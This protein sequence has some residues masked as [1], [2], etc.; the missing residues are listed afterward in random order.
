MYN[1][2][3]KKLK[4]KQGDILSLNLISDSQIMIKGKKFY[5]DFYLEILKLCYAKIEVKMHLIM[6]KLE[7]VLLPAKLDVKLYSTFLKILEKKPDIIIRHCG[8]KEHHERYF[9]SFYK[10]L[11]YYLSNY[12]SDKIGPLLEKKDLWKYYVD[13][14][15]KNHQYFPNLK[16]PNELII[17]MI[18][19][20]PSDFSTI[21]GALSFLNDTEKL[22]STINDNCK[23]I[24]DCCTKENQLIEISEISNP[25]NT[26]DL[27]KVIDIIEKLIKYQLEKGKHFISFG[28]KFWDAYIKLND[29]KNLKNLI[30]INK[31][32]IQ[33][34]KIDKNLNDKKLNLIEKIHN[35]GLE[36]IKKGEIKNENLLN[37]IQNEDIYFIDKKYESDL[38]RPLSI[39]KGIDLDTADQKFYELW[40]FSKIFE[41]YSFNDS[42]KK[43]LIDKIY[44][45]K[46]FGKV[47]LLFNI[48]TIDNSVISLLRQ[49]FINIIKTYKIEKCPNF[50]KDMALFIY[51]VD[52]K[53]KKVKNFMEKTIEQNIS[54]IQT[55][56]DI[57][58]HLAAN[59]KDISKEV[60]GNIINYF[61]KNKMIYSQ[62]FLNLLK[63]GNNNIVTSILKEID[64]YVIKEQDIL[65]EEKDVDSF[66]LLDN[67]KKEELL[68][69]CPELNESNYLMNIL[70]LG[71]IFIKK[72]KDGDISYRAL[73]P[74]MS[75]EEKKD[76]LK[77]RLNILY[78]NN[79][80]DID[81]CLKTLEEK[82]MKVKQVDDYIKKLLGVLKEF[83]REKYYGEI[84]IIEEIEKKIELG[85]L[86]ILEDTQDKNMFD[87]IHQIFPDLDT[88]Y[89]KLKQSQFFVHIFRTKKEKSPKKK[90]D[91]ILN[92]ALKDFE[93]LKEL[94]EDNW[95]YKIDE[96]VMNECYNALKT[97]KDIRTEINII[98]DYFE[99]EDIDELNLDRLEDELIIYKKKDE[100]YQ[101]TNNCINFIKEFNVEETNLSSLL[102]NLRNE[103]CKVVS[104]DRIKE[105]VNPLV[106][107]GINIFTQKPEDKEYINII[108]SLCSNKDSLLFI[109]QL[110]EDKCHT[111]QKQVISKKTALTEEDIQNLTKCSNFIHSFKGVK[112]DKELI[113]LLIEK[114][115]QVKNISDYFIRYT[116]NF[117]QIQELYS[118][119]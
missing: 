2:V 42:F 95:V 19:K 100:I 85:K 81:D 17:E 111:L 68:D 34:K 48:K 70:D 73:Y 109:L 7:R 25:K 36:A 97:M 71:N 80:E 57:Y 119:E 79:Q 49:K 60:I 64:K 114:V 63:L 106:K 99:L 117:E 90:E 45:M 118:Q 21:K 113:S 26:D 91:E 96:L 78:F 62:K 110:T 104:P 56:T 53:T 40:Q 6:F 10:L 33:Y 116:K 44:D 9:I 105:C 92:E 65:S 15:P 38:Y 8:E 43:K 11:L 66:K 35:N 37:F 82:F 58:L 51:F 13:I 22:L 41:I 77:K 72:C 16:I 5:L 103:L 87:E 30:L 4:V 102:N 83:Y 55:I 3:L 1:E 89:D 27:N 115:P 98:K 12:E 88:K 112:T 32:V 61:I 108:N 94:Y 93:K 84:K 74:L 18:K 69:K 75:N 86:N 47:C 29:K 24:Y 107:Y 31:T 59:Y 46:D 14:L 101:F 52:K 54:S 39:L 76:L 20:Q 28:L 67:I 50:I 23:I